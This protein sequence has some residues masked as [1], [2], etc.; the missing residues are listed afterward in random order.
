MSNNNN[1]CLYWCCRIYKC[2]SNYWEKTPITV[3]WR[4]Y[5][6]YV[7]FL[8]AKMLN[9]D[10]KES[11]KSIRKYVKFYFPFNWGFTIKL[12]QKGKIKCNKVL[13]PDSIRN[14]FIVGQKTWRP[15]TLKQTKHLNVSCLSSFA[16]QAVVLK[17]SVIKA[18]GLLWLAGWD[19]PAG[20]WARKTR[21]PQWGKSSTE[22]SKSAIAENNGIFLWFHH[23]RCVCRPDVLHVFIPSYFQRWSEQFNLHVEVVENEEEECDTD[24]ER[25]NVEEL[26]DY[27][28]HQHQKESQELAYDVQHK[29]LIPVLRRYQSQAVNW[30]LKREKY[31]NSTPKG[32]IV[33]S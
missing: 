26:Y 10:L 21:V 13:H 33:T 4:S 19:L 7:A 14:F 18:A 15:C 8:G 6:N 28:R 20:G 24:L 17:I 25:Q 1:S 12:M 23:S 5:L 9:F 29:A 22:E 16:V 11:T 27:I 3:Y 31:R 32:T 2:F 30:M